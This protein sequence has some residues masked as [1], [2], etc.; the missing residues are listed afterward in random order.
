M[1]LTQMLNT[2]SSPFINLFYQ[3]LLVLHAFMHPSN[4]PSL[5]LK[6]I[7]AATRPHVK[8]VANI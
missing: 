5:S 7:L 3:I 1:L 4:Q 8:T 2:T 6:N